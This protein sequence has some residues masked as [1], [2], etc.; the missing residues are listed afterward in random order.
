VKRFFIALLAYLVLRTPL[1]R[2]TAPARLVAYAEAE[3]QALQRRAVLP[4]GVSIEEAEEVHRFAQGE[5]RAGRAIS[6]ADV[7]RLIPDLSRAGAAELLLW[8]CLGAPGAWESVEMLPR[9]GGRFAPATIVPMQ[10]A[11]EGQGG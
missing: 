9:R 8:V 2:V 5:H 7:Q 6:T 3:R 4:Q 10:T 1:G 11:G